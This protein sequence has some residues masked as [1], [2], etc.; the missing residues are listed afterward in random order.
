[1]RAAVMRNRQLVVDTIPDP[2]PQSGEVLVRTLACGICG[3]DLHFLKHADRMVEVMVDSGFPSTLDLG[4]DLVMGHEF[5]AEVIDY[6]PDTAPTVTAGERV[7][8]MPLSFRNGMPAAVGYSNDLPGGY[9]ELMVLSAYTILPV[10]N[11]L[12]TEHA[13]LTE[14]MA[15]GVHAV[16]KGNLQPGDAPLVIGCGPVGLAVIAALKM[17]GAS[18]IVAADYSPK[19]RALAAKMGADVVID[20][21]QRPTYEAYREAANLAPSLIFECVGVAGLLQQILR[22]APLGARV[23]VVGVC[24]D[25]DMIRP[26][27]AINKEINLQFVLAY[28]P[29]EF[30]DTLRALSEGQ[31]DATPLITGQI[32][33]EGVP[34]AFESLASPEAHAKILVQPGK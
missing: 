6:G 12:S 3:S 10:P 5:S 24:M 19:R 32:G 9:G 28:T 29:V 7:V 16:N 11:G 30:A 33:I 14:P 20:P 26:I 15:V 34:A 1:M 22:G 27:Y 25:D 23:V 18:P 4:C 21:A 8:S 17:R 31:I 2:V 13:A